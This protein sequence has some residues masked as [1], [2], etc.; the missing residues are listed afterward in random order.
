[1]FSFFA[2]ATAV[3]VGIEWCCTTIFFKVWREKFIN[4]EADSLEC[5]ARVFGVT[6]TFLCRH[7]EIVCRYKHLHVTFKLD[8]CKYT[9]CNLNSLFTATTKATLEAT[10][11]VFGHGIT[12]IA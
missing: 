12:T 2:S 1:M 9:K 6:A 4:R 3:C 7:T 10:T 5:I 8:Y 11:D